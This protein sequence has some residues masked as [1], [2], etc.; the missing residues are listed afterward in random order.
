MEVLL[1]GG[2][3]HF[4]CVK[5][6]HQK[7]RALYFLFVAEAECLNQ[8]GSQRNGMPTP[9]WQQDDSFLGTPLGWASY[10][11]LH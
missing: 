3:R 10:C 9:P 4:D 11:L 8:E 1:W 7:V 6:D 5:K 2:R